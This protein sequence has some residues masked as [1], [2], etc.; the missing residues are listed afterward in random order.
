MKRPIIMIIFLLSVLVFIAGCSSSESPAVSP[1]PMESAQV[2]ENTDELELDDDSEEIESGEIGIIGDRLSKAYVDMMANDNFTMVYKT[3]MDIEGEEVEAKMTMVSSDDRVAFKMNYESMSST[4][5]M[6]ED[7]MYIVSDDT[8][9]VMIMPFGLDDIEDELD[10]TSQLQDIDAS[11]MDYIGRGTGTF[12]GNTRDYEE[13]RVDDNERIFYYFD[14]NSLDG[15]EIVS[16]SD[17]TIIDVEVMTDDVDE[18]IFDIPENY[19]TFE[20]GG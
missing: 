9:T 15:M 4:T 20:I 14:G 6:K 1:D 2:E 7:K 17:T 10:D 5:I 18:S 3:I 19:Q 8:Q 13:Y 11:S 12:M 16:D